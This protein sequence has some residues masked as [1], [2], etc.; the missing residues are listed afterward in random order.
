MLINISNKENNMGA[1]AGRTK[2]NMWKSGP[3][4]LVHRKYQPFL[5]ARAQARF[6][7]E[8]WTLTWE[9]WQELWP[10]ELWDQRG[11][12]TEELAMTRKDHRGAWSMDNVHIV[13]RGQQLYES[14]LRRDYEGEKARRKARKQ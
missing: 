5:A 1:I 9:Q 11:K 7:S 3:D 13:T 8:E 6:R 10:H 14:N 12:K 2:P 4:P